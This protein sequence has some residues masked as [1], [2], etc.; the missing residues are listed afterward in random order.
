MSTMTK[1]SGCPFYVAL[2]V[3]LM[4]ALPTPSAQAVPVTLTFEDLP[5]ANLFLGG[6]ENIGGF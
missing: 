5:D 2:V 1:R 3:V 4:V 6:W